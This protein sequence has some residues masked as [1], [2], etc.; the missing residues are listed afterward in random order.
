MRL[1][2]AVAIAWPTITGITDRK[3]E[4]MK[5][6]LRFN[7]GIYRDKATGELG[8]WAEIVYETRGTLYG[9]RFYD[10]GEPYQVHKAHDPC[11]V[12]N[13]DPG[14]RAVVK[15]ADGEAGKAIRDLLAMHPDALFWNR[16]WWRAKNAVEGTAV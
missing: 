9:A 1:P 12:N 14:Y 10:T 8:A 16:A 6:A 5:T 15:V 13:R 3:G 11:K 4:T 7:D 2:G